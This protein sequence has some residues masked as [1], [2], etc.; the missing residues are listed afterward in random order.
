MKLHPLGILHWHTHTHALQSDS[1]YSVVVSDVNKVFDA[2][3]ENINLFLE[4]EELLKELTVLDV[5]D[6]EIAIHFEDGKLV[7]VLKSGK[8]AFWNVLKKHGFKVVDIR[9]PEV[10]P[11][12][13]ASIYSSPKLA[14]FVGYYEVANHEKGI[15][16]YN[17]VIQKTLE[18]GRYFFWKSPVLVTV[19][20]VDMRQ[21]Q[22]D[23]TGQEIMMEDKITLRLN[24]ICHYRIT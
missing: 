6:Y 18:P 23:M 5:Q 24:F 15:L 10:S 20:N 21:Q 17:N 4:D 13:D 7:D 14:G 3:G 16:Y 12:I 22:L 19:K 2:A 8:Y 11:D 1:K 9:N